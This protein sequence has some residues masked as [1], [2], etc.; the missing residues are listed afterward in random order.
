MEEIHGNKKSKPEVEI[1]YLL[2][3]QFTNGIW[4]VNPPLR[5]RDLAS[6]CNVH[7][8]SISKEDKVCTIGMLE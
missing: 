3:K 6:F 4:K 7:T 5:F 2:K 8:L 1:H